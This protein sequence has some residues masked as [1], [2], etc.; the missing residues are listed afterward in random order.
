MERSQQSFHA[1]AMNFVLPQHPV[2]F[3]QEDRIRGKSDTSSQMNPDLSRHTI[4][5]SNVPTDLSI[6]TAKKVAA[7]VLQ[8]RIDK[9]ISENQAIVETFDS[10]WP[11][12]YMRQNSKDAEGD[13]NRLAQT[14]QM[15]RQKFV[16]SIL[17]ECSIEIP[18]QSG[19]TKTSY[20]ESILRVSRLNLSV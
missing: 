11:R 2:A 13:K 12:R 5:N 3:P 8:Q 18:F 9:V 4:T 7:E 1:D 16:S 20:Y 17:F 10:L 14:F 19:S 6:G 15:S